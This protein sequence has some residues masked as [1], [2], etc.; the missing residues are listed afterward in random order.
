[1]TAPALST[2][3]HR[4]VSAAKVR[5]KVGGPMGA[6]FGVAPSGPE[7]SHGTMLHPNLPRATS[8]PELGGAY[9]PAARARAEGATDSLWNLTEYERM[10]PGNVSG[11]GT[12]T[13]G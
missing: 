12:E 9:D 6:D 8:N 11:F 2:A 1:M 3:Y 5:F 7:L 13:I 4:G 10:A